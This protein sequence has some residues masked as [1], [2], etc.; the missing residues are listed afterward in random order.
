MKAFP[1]LGM[2]LGLICLPT[3][4]DPAGT[5]SIGLLNYTN[6]HFPQTDWFTSSLKGKPAQT[7]Q[8]TINIQELAQSGDLTFDIHRLG[9]D[10]KTGSSETAT[11]HNGSV[12]LTVNPFELVTMRSKP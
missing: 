10:N 2:G 5:W 3:W 11:L 6:D 7:L 8:V 1:I 9:P 4:A 12:T